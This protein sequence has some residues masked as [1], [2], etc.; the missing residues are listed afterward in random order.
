MHNNDESKII[1]EIKPDLLKLPPKG[2]I[3]PETYFLLKQKSDHDLSN[4]EEKLTPK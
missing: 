1:A 4:F 2:E 3:K